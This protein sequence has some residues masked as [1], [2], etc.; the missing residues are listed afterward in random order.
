MPL[1]HDKIYIESMIIG[2]VA[3]FIINSMLIPRFSGVG[4]AVGTIVAEFTVMIVQMIGI[5][6]EFPIFLFCWKSIP[7]VVI[8]F[9]MQIIVRKYGIFF[10]VSI[11]TLIGQVVIGGIVYCTLCGCYFKLFK[12]ELGIIIISEINKKIKRKNV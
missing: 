4:A 11:T 2:A 8:G 9:I 1:H 10:G 5:R 3:N 12:D 6:K 7:Y